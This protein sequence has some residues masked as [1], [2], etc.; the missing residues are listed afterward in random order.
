MMT[1]PWSTTWSYFNRESEDFEDIFSWVPLCQRSELDPEL[2]SQLI[3]KYRA[4][5]PLATEDQKIELSTDELCRG[6]MDRSKKD[7]LGQLFPTHF[8][9]LAIRTYL[10]KTPIG[11]SGRRSWSKDDIKD[12]LDVHVK[13]FIHEYPEDIK[14]QL[15]ETF[16]FGREHN[17]VKVH[18]NSLDMLC[19][20]MIVYSSAALVERK[21]KSC[22]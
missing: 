15:F 13:H 4:N 21:L 18:L 3:E 7:I 14:T 1:V 12:L 8:A 17:D 2:K 16:H 11:G 10:A 20:L 9:E 5:V 6:L 22:G 19:L